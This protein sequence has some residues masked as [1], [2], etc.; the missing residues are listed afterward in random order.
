VRVGIGWC[1]W[2]AFGGSFSLRSGGEIRP[3]GDTW[4]WLGDETG[5]PSIERRASIAAI[6]L[7]R[8]CVAGRKKPGC[9]SALNGPPNDGP[10][11]GR[12][13]GRWHRKTWP[14]N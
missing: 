2:R 7:F 13:P 12:E 4:S 1:T 5:A 8:E 3:A 6:G 11:T 14:G 10:G 9:R